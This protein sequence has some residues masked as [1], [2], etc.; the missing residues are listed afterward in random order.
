[1]FCKNKNN[2]YSNMLFY[3]QVKGHIYKN[4]RLVV[5]T[6]FGISENNLVKLVS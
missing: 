1:M 5:C 4:C 6:E 3:T 2:Y